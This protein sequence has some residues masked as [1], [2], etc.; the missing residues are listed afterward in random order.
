[1]T[2]QTPEPVE[3]APPASHP[4]VDQLADLQEELLAATEAAE[5][6][7]HLSR[8]PDCAD[9]LAALAELTELLA[10]D[11]PPAMPADVARRID[12]ALAAALAEP[13]TARTT[14]GTARTA[15]T[16]AP[17][18]PAESAAPPR[19]ADRSTGPGRS[20]QRRRGTLLAAAVACLAV[21]GLGTVV[22]VSGLGD[23]AHQAAG[24]AAAGAQQGKPDTAMPAT[25]SG[26]PG[27]PAF[28]AAGL[29]EQ[30]RQLLPTSPSGHSSLP[31]ASSEQENPTP[32]AAPAKLPSCVQGAVAGHRDEQPLL[33]THGSFQ[34]A[35]VDVYVFRVSGSSTA[36]DVFLLT[37]GCADGT[38]A[39][40]LLHEEVPAS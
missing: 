7:E 26:S 31:H 30:I 40:V 4:T 16:A 33:V 29:P 19:R 2:N 35:P 36:L 18:R 38:P 17:Q 22:V 13:A 5:L 23:D 14:A 28:T 20:R 39:G 9:T 24:S 10:E 25:P 11:E 8:C 37:P 12:A 1:M 21:L 3:S 34:S 27:G 15:A 6:R 32:N